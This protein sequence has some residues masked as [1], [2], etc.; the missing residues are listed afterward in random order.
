MALGTFLANVISGWSIPATTTDQ[1]SP[2]TFKELDLQVAKMSSNT[3]E[4]T[5]KMG[6]ILINMGTKAANTIPET[7]Y[8]DSHSTTKNYN[9]GNNTSS[10]KAFGAFKGTYLPC[11]SNPSA[12]NTSDCY[13]FI[14][15]KG[16]S[17][18]STVQFVSKISQWDKVVWNAI[19]TTTVSSNTCYLATVY[20][21]WKNYGIVY[22][23][24]TTDNF[25]ETADHSGAGNSPHTFPIPMPGTYRMECWGA[26]GG[27]GYQSPSSTSTSE[28]ALYG[29]GAYT[30]GD[31]TFNET[32]INIHP[33]LYIYVGGRG[34]SCDGKRYAS[35]TGGYN[36]GGN[37]IGDN[38]N[39][40]SGGGGGGASDIRIS[41]GAWNSFSSLKDRIMVAA[42]AGGSG[43]TASSATSHSEG[44]QG[45][46]TSNTGAITG[47]LSLWYA[48][49]T[50]T[51][52]Y[53]FGYGQNGTSYPVG[54]GGGGGGYWGGVSNTT[55]GDSYNPYGKAA[56]G[57]SFV[58]GHPDCIGCAST[59]SSTF[60]ARTDANKN[61]HYS[62]LIFNSSSITIISGNNTMPSPTAASKTPTNSQI[63]SGYSTE[64]SGH[65]TDGY[66]RIT[67]FPYGK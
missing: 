34:Q 62:G 7:S 23:Y 21:K 44:M 27:R 52:G 43:C 6:I 60:A 61:Q 49:S 42:G 53:R 35:R 66:V 13:G 47:W 16:S 1:S 63:T 54:N 31:I 64:S 45:G 37:G 9:T 3:F 56:G 17:P 8:F 22:R 24:Q 59:A 28:L 41:N 2:T 32:I 58:S 25:T 36:G 12:V 14:V 39:T 40:D 18:N 15:Q 26:A 11:P 67:F 55:Q 10:V 30:A 38:D 48:N 57:S 65:Q 51:T 29:R 19:S 4:M 50:Q 5:H 20:P 46:G 33:N